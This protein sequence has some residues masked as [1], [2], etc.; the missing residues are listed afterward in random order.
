[1]EIHLTAEQESVISK[2]EKLLALSRNNS[3][4]AEA[5]SAAAK[6]MEL[7][8]AYNLDMAI[9]GQTS[10]QDGKRNDKKRKG[11]LYSW[12]RDLWHAVSKLNF[13]RYWFIRGLGRGTQYEHRILG[14]QENVIATELMAEYLQD[15]IER[16]TVEYGKKH[17]PGKSR[18][19]RELIA[20]REGMAN[21]LYWRLEDLR[22]QRITEDRRKADEARAR[23][24][25]GGTALVLA[26]VIQTEDDLNEDYLMGLE[27]GTTAKRRAEREA[28]RAAAQAAYNQQMAEEQAKWDAFA[29]ANPEEA[30]RIVR[31]RERKAKEQEAKWAAEDARR[32]KQPSRERKLTSREQRMQ[33][34]EFYAG[35]DK[36][37]EVGLDKQIDKSNT[38][39]IA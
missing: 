9:V 18:F 29:A 36:A 1:M 25:H 11:G 13:C 10:K 21:R 16:L 35:Y 23:H 12:Q 24:S 17:Y 5:E 38:K 15:T 7:L 19:I 30:A 4:E 34:H 39:R 20:Y 33:S 27:P 31:E 8:A 32:A 14:R 28:R 3:N 37:G 2:V 6:A 26:D 22:H